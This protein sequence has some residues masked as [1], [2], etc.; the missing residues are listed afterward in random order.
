MGWG[1]LPPFLALNISPSSLWLLCL[2][3]CP[4]ILVTSP[5]RRPPASL[6]SPDQS[7]RHHCVPG[8]ASQP[9]DPRL[10]S[11]N[12]SERI[13][14]HLQQMGPHIT[15]S[16]WGAGE[17]GKKGHRFSK[18]VTHLI[19]NVTSHIHAQVNIQGAYCKT[20]GRSGIPS[21]FFTEKA[22]GRRQGTVRVRCF[23]TCKVRWGEM[24]SQKP[25]ASADV[26][27]H[28]SKTDPAKCMSPASSSPRCVN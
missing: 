6:L 11:E 14:Q 13:P 28:L 10:G 25:G 26:I 18:S 19:C 22:E 12:I 2:M 8:P 1:C 20:R 21:M 15:W 16:P 4:L 27:S 5:A 24:D 7:C 3:I 17:Q 23:H 9:S